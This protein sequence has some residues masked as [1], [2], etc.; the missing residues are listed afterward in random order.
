[1]CYQKYK[2]YLTQN[3]HSKMTNSLFLDAADF[4]NNIANELIQSKRVTLCKNKRLELLGTLGTVLS[5]RRYLTVYRAAI[6]AH[7]G[8]SKK[9][10]L[11]KSLRIAKATNARLQKS[12]EA[13]IIRRTE[14]ADYTIIN[15]ADI[16]A[17]IEKATALLSS[18]NSRYKVAA[19]LLLLTGRRT[20]E[21]FLTGN[22]APVKGTKT[23]VSFTGQLKKR[24]HET[25]ISS[26]AYNIPILCENT[27]VIDAANWIK[28]LYN[29]TVKP[30]NAKAITPKFADIA[31]VNK[32]VSR[33]LGL[34]VKAE[35]SDVLG[36]D[37]SP[38]DLR[39]AYAAICFYLGGKGTFRQTA[40]KIL[41]HGAGR[42]EL[43]SEAY[44]KYKVI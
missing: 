6:K 43:T 21:I 44:A 39:K 42:A 35:F 10:A 17:L 22:F 41:G 8:I 31:D 20:A 36:V 25:S 13:K 23:K 32:R 38:H 40:Q 33:D 34:A 37:V 29:G 27:K 9:T 4:A 12:Y 3:I 7:D 11:L 15:S 24:G 30:K 26:G 18:E 5:V 1:M 28:S 2:T 19:G 16:P 14:N